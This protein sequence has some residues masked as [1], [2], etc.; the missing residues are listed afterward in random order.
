MSA[1][2]KTK[3]NTMSSSRWVVYEAPNAMADDSFFFFK[4]PNAMRMA[5]EYQ[6][7]MTQDRSWKFFSVYSDHSLRGAFYRLHAIISQLYAF[8]ALYAWWFIS[9]SR[10]LLQKVTSACAAS[11]ATY[12]NK[13]TVTVTVTVTLRM[14]LR[15]NHHWVIGKLSPLRPVN[16]AQQYDVARATQASSRGL[17]LVVYMPSAGIIGY[18]DKIYILWP[19]DRLRLRRHFF[20]CSKTDV[21]MHKPEEILT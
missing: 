6:G 21:C 7:Q 18:V 15:R 17:G 3:C 14:M 11:Q 10:G 16:P 20:P 8:Y 1:F 9:R 19:R 13:Y 2:Y 4:K 5:S 12:S